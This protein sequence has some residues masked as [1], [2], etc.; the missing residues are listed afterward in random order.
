MARLHALAFLALASGMGLTPVAH[1]AT[2]D[3]KVSI[4]NFTFEPAEITVPAGSTVAWVNHDDIPHTVTS[5]EKLF[6]SPALDTDDGYTMTFDKPGTY[7]YFC[8]LHPHMTGTVVV[9]PAS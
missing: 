2:T 6:K 5:S 3:A 9:T 4:E 7:P 8:A 1:A